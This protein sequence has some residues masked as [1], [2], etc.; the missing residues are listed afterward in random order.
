[1]VVQMLR[2]CHGFCLWLREP[3]SP[4]GKGCQIPE[5][6]QTLPRIDD[7]TSCGMQHYEAPPPPPSTQPNHPPHSIRNCTS[8][9]V[10]VMHGEKALNSIE[11]FCANKLI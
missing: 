10:D 7:S 3:N 1:M 2:Q 6:P 5:N 9:E 4:L 11:E 8:R